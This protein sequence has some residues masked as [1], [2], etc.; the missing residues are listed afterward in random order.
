MQFGDLVDKVKREVSKEKK[1]AA[2]AV[3]RQ[4]LRELDA[5]KR[6]V[7]TL[8]RQLNELCRK[9]LDEVAIPVPAVTVI[10]SWGST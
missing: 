10:A 3:L 6:T 2:K 8:E 9:E 7:A 4:K 1:E 5:A